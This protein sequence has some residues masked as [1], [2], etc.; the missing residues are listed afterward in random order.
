M[1]NCEP[2]CIST[3]GRKASLIEKGTASIIADDITP[4]MHY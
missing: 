1:G 3:D 2:C 4:G